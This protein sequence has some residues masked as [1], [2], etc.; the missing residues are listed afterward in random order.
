[1]AESPQL[2]SS[3]NSITPKCN[4][5]HDSFLTPTRFQLVIDDPQYRDLS[6]NCQTVNIPAVSVSAIDTP[7]QQF[8][9]SMTGSKINFEPL[10]ARFIIDEDLSNYSMIYE[11]LITQVTSG[12]TEQDL[13]RDVSLLIYNSDNVLTVE[14]T[15]IDAFPTSLSAVEF[16]T[17]VD[18]GIQ[19]LNA[20]IVFK[21]DY[22]KI[23]TKSKQI[24]NEQSI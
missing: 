19:Y 4:V 3:V 15:F 14:F 24:D 22:Y 11:W 10:Q 1:M 17:T 12:K 5:D 13:K 16:D 23:K 18:G 20:D 2:Y 7:Y 9:P 21:F 6:F 8:N